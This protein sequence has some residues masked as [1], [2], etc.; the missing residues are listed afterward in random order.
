MYCEVYNIC[1]HKTREKA[2]KTGGWHE[3]W[4]N[5][6]SYI[7]V[8]QRRKDIIKPRARLSM[9]CNFVIPH[10]GETDWKQRMTIYQSKKQEAATCMGTSTR[11]EKS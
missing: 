6:Q 10:S 3:K 1:R 11:V 7:V 4:Y 5:I 9:T 8:S 2:Q